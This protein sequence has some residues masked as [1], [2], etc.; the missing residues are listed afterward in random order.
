MIENNLKPDFVMVSFSTLETLFGYS[1]KADIAHFAKTGSRQDL[2]TQTRQTYAFLID[3]L[4]PKLL[5]KPGTKALLSERQGYRVIPIDVQFLDL[6]TFFGIKVAYHKIELPF[7]DLDQFKPKQ[8]KIE[9]FM[10]KHQVVLI[11]KLEPIYTIQN[12]IT[13]SSKMQEL[14]DSMG[15]EMKRIFGVPK[16]I[17]FT[18]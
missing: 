2:P 14:I 5:A 10:S 8:Q 9:T 1:A 3:T 13:F 17:D 7:S 15:S 12:R 11:D 18:N 16:T 6:L 4:S